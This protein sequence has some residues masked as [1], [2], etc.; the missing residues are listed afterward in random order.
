[1]QRHAPVLFRD[2]EKADENHTVN[3]RAVP[4]GTQCVI[5]A[6]EPGEDDSE[7]SAG[8]GGEAAVDAAEESASRDC[9]AEGAGEVCS[10]TAV[11]M[12]ADMMRCVHRKSKKVREER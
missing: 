12:T 4:G 7:K 5:H 11:S 2:T 6:G 8:R 9:A 10:S 3:K 1:M